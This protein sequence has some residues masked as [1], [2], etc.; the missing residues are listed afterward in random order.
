MVHQSVLATGIFKLGAVRT[1]AAR[2]D[3][4]FI[5]DADPQNAF[6]N[7]IVRV[8]S[9][10]PLEKRRAVAEAIM[11]VIAAK[12][13]G[14]GDS[15]GLAL[16]VYVEEIDEDGALRKN[17]LAR[18]HGSARATERRRMNKPAVPYMETKNVAVAFGSHSI[19]R[20]GVKFGGDMPIPAPVLY[21]PFNIVRLSHVVLT[22]TDLQASR[23]F[24]FDTLGLQVTDETSD[25][26]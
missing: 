14:I 26:I 24:Y 22:V 12:T 2:R 20:I 3:I 19:A 4:F 16:S 15:R 6:I 9:G 5:A 11:G 8:A 7:V 25:A 21:P 10:R 17:N 13:A 18:P 1:R 23:A